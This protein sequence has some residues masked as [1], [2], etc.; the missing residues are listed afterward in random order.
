MARRDITLHRR[1]EAEQDDILT[2]RT[3]LWPKLKATLRLIP[4]T[5]DLLAAYFCAIDRRTP[6]TAKAVLMGALAYFVIPFDSVPDFLAAL[7]YTDD[8]AV[9]LGAIRAVQTHIKP[10]H[11]ERAKAALA[12]ELEATSERN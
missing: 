1:E 5:E 10:D 8:L 3:G 9:L 7:G 11:R 6:A 12:D 4:F 2:V